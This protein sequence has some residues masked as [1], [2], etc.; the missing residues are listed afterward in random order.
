MQVMLCWHDP[1]NAASHA[2]WAAA[3]LPDAQ[4][5]PQNGDVHHL[6]A[7]PI[8]KAVLKVRR[9]AGSAWGWGEFQ[10]GVTGKGQ[11]HSFVHGYTR[12]YSYG[13]LV[14]GMLRVDAL[15][16]SVSLT[17][18]AATAMLG[19]ALVLLVFVACMWRIGPC[20][21]LSVALVFD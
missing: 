13:P 19:Y 5:L 8:S 1:G 2:M 18:W 3:L 6:L 15:S 10:R 20:A 17:R 9:Q 4:D 14:L 12:T 16:A 11:C 21:L 7:K